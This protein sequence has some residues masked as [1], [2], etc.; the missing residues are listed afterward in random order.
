MNI[1]FDCDLRFTI[2]LMIIAHEYGGFTGCSVTAPVTKAA[3]ECKEG[4]LS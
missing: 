1:V 4:L 3:E 2:L